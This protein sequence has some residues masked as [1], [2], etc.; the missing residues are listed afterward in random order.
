MLKNDSTAISARNRQNPDLDDGKNSDISRKNSFRTNVSKRYQEADDDA[1]SSKSN[2][3]SSR[4]SCDGLSQT[5]S[6]K[7]AEPA[8]EKRN[9][10]DI[11][12]LER[13]ALAA[14]S[15]S[16]KPRELSQNQ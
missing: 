15:K 13:L 8:L 2:R 3:S 10:H 9:T 4:G 12:S 11:K 6:Q 16:G 5:Y 7:R 1:S 14:S